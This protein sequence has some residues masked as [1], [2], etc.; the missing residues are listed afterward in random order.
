M[1][2]SMK[3]GNHKYMSP[4]NPYGQGEYMAQK[5][6]QNKI[7]TLTFRGQMEEKQPKSENHS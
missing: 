6:I 2:S 1:G 3:F 5:E 4:Q 7:P